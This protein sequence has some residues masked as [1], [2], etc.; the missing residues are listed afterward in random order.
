[1]DGLKWEKKGPN[2]GEGNNVRGRVGKVMDWLP[3]TDGRPCQGSS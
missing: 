3:G 2:L 1:M